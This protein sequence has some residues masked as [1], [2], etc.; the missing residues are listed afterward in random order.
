[1][2]NGGFTLLLP[3]YLNP[4]V[5]F[6]DCSAIYQRHAKI[7]FNLVETHKLEKSRF[8]WKILDFIIID[9]QVKVGIRFHSNN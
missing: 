5:K 7:V 1:M 8:K 6:R 9:K 2:Q 4:K 3:F